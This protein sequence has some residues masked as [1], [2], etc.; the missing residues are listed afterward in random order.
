MPVM[1]VCRMVPGMVLDYHAAVWLVSTCLSIDILVRG[2]VMRG[3]SC[4]LWRAGG[5]A[6]YGVE[7]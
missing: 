4:C 3:S 2:P 1:A 7:D 5:F 6:W